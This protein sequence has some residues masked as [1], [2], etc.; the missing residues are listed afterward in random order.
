MLDLHIQSLIIWLP[1]YCRVPG[2]QKPPGTNTRTE[3]L[4]G[5]LAFRIPEEIES[6]F[7]GAKVNKSFWW[8]FKCLPVHEVL[9]LILKYLRWCAEH[10]FYLSNTYNYK[11]PKVPLI[12]YTVYNFSSLTPNMLVRASL[13]C[14][15]R[16]LSSLD[17]VDA[18]LPTAANTLEI[19]CK[20]KK[21]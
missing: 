15:T 2:E 17:W 5:P 1:I 7:K 16:V 6:I 18:K 13:F 20:K 12:D 10:V 14:W 19:L 9:F 21:K 3:V 8:D 11:W 4:T